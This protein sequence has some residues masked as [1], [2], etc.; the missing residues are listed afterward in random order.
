MGIYL[1]QIRR[2]MAWAP[3]PREGR[4]LRYVYGTEA[5]FGHMIAGDPAKARHEDISRFIALSALLP[6]EPFKTGILRVL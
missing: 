3:D 5:L 2:S 6:C 1:F 4:F